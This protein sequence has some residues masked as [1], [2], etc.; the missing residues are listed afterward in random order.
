MILD[1]RNII[2]MRMSSPSASK[3]ELKE[4]L[5]VFTE[6]AEMSGYSVTQQTIDYYNDGSSSYHVVEVEGVK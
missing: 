5:K 1:K 3:E 2:S 4:Q 6:I